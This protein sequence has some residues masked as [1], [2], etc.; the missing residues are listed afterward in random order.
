MGLRELM[1]VEVEEREPERVNSLEYLQRIY[2]DP[3]QPTS[4]R[5]RAAIEAL[6]FE[7]RKLSSIGVGYLTNDTFAERLERAID[8]SDRAKVIEARAIEVEDH[9]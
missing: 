3:M 6:Q 5:M 4:V 7:N 8:R 2:R 9:E 1:R